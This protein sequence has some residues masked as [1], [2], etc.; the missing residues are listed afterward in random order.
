PIIPLGIGVK[1][2][3]DIHRIFHGNSQA[4]TCSVGACAYGA[5]VG[6]VDELDGS[7]EEQWRIFARGRC[8]GHQQER[9]DVVG[10]GIRRRN[11]AVDR[12]GKGAGGLEVVEYSQFS[13]ISQRC[14]GSG[15]RVN[16]TGVGA[17][18]EEG[19]RAV[20]VFAG[21]YRVIGATGGWIGAVGKVV[22]PVFSGLVTGKGEWR[23]SARDFAVGVVATAVGNID[24]EIVRR[25]HRI[26][27]GW[28]GGHDGAQLPGEPV[29]QVFAV[30]FDVLHN[31][32]HRGTRRSR[33][34]TVHRYIAKCPFARIEERIGPEVVCRWRPPGHELARARFNAAY[35]PDR[36]LQRLVGSGSAKRSDRDVPKLL[37]RSGVVTDALEPDDRQRVRIQAII[38]RPSLLGS[39]RV[40]GRECA[41][42]GY[43]DGGRVGESWSVLVA[44]LYRSGAIHRN[45]GNGWGL[46][47]IHRRGCA[48]P[49]RIEG[50]TVQ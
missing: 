45:V 46:A 21:F 14:L 42:S 37:Q 30:N 49:L 2:A 43:G 27:G 23:P 16:P 40:D 36:G 28:A 20:H 41:A 22:P 4:A 39:Q 25:N 1:V 13:I 10:G 9:P 8:V 7:A 17:V 50:R 5:E 11:R 24:D 31:S 29:G 48:G 15:D 3:L 47:D 35:R 38:S 6:S 18:G 19:A 26:L 44:H 12:I 34:T 33:S 32:V